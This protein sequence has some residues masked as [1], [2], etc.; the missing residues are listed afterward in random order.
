MYRYNLFEVIYFTVFGIFLLE[1]L[2]MWLSKFRKK[3]PK[4]VELKKD[5][6]PANSK[7]VVEFLNDLL[8]TKFDY[9]TYKEILPIYIGNETNKKEKFKKEKFLKLKEFYFKDISMSLSK[10]IKKELINLFTEQGIE[11]YIHQYFATH[12]NKIDAKFLNM[13]ED[14]KGNM[15]FMSDNGIN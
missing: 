7:Y 12:F 8:K 3:K 4:K 13:E 14:V 9:Y 11:I 2:I 1:L 5:F 6:V 15:F 10:N